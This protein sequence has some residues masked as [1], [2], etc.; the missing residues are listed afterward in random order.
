[1]NTLIID[2]LLSKTYS[3]GVKALKQITLTI[4]NRLFGLLDPNGA[5]KSS[6]IRTLTA[7]QEPT[8]GNVL[9]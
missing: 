7:L 9:F 6:L 5:G 4:P 1:M 2:G 8:Q 3:N